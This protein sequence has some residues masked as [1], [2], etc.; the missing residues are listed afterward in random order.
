MQVAENAPCMSGVISDAHVAGPEMT[1]L[2]HFAAA[3]A[4]SARLYRR[5]HRDRFV[6]NTRRRY[7]AFY[8]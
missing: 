3:A 2:N 4:N 1:N 5:G 6:Y 7:G 8:A